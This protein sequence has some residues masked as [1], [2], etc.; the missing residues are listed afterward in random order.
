MIAAAGAGPACHC[1]YMHAMDD[2]CMD[3]WCSP[4]VA[5]GELC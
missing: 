3:Q 1:Q 5:H 2:A 4:S